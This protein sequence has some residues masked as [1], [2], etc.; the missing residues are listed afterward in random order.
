MIYYKEDSEEGGVD[1]RPVEIIISRVD[2]LI[3]EL[4]EFVKGLVVLAGGS[5]D[6]E[7]K[8]R[9]IRTSCSAISKI[10]GTLPSDYKEEG[11]NSDDLKEI[12]MI[13]DYQTLREVNNLA[14]IVDDVRIKG[15]WKIPGKGAQYPEVGAIKAKI[16]KIIVELNNLSEL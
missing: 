9:L 12:R 7:Q 1:S 6:A 2:K 13:L 11:I 4:L 10:L 3:K 5:N 16:D 8:Y 15:N 14:G